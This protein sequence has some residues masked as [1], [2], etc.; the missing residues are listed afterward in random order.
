MISVRSFDPG[1]LGAVISLHRECFPGVAQ[2]PLDEVERKYKQLWVD[3]PFQHPRLPALVACDQDGGVVGVFLSLIRWWSLGDEKIPARTGTAR[4]V[5]PALQRQG[6]YRELVEV[7]KKNRAGVHGD[8]SIGFSDRL[9]P[10]MVARDR[11]R[12]EK[13]TLLDEYGFT[14]VIPL[15][16]RAARIRQ[17]ESV[18]LRRGAPGAGLGWAARTIGSA[19]EKIV[20][21]ER[22]DLP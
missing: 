15:R 20:A 8:R 19:M 21:D 7:W 11:R 22:P 17:I 5:S 1:D 14:W 12:P 18:L 6:I 16:R 3:S 13:I 10:V 9:T 4:A 2:R